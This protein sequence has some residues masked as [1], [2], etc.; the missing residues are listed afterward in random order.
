M[1]IQF[2]MKSYPPPPPPNLTFVASYTPL[3][4]PLTHIHIF[5]LFISPQWFQR[6]HTPAI[7][8][9]KRQATLDYLKIYREFSELVTRDIGLF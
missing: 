1:V 4:S 5:N 7:F 8:S 3:P 9:E 2:P 6:V